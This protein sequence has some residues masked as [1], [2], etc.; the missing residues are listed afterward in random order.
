[1]NP[2]LEVTGLSIGRNGRSVLEDISFSLGQGESAGLAGPNGAGKSTLLWC[3]LGLLHGRGRILKPDAT[4][5]V[6]QNPEDQLFMPSLLEDLMLPLLCAGQDRTRASAAAKDALER[7]E[8]GPLAQT[9]ASELSLGQRKRA[10]LALALVRSP[11]LL[12]L[13]EPTAE[14]DPR[15]ARLFAATLQ[16]S[17]AARLVASH[18]LIFLRRTCN[19]LIILDQGRIRADGPTQNLAGDHAL[20][21]RHGLI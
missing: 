20:L 3:I 10:A 13:D 5:A 8:M 2:V 7:L 16:T 19:R 15:S 17:Q 1:M 12:L 18:D 6:F 9:P 4:A 14:L 11:Q 21:E